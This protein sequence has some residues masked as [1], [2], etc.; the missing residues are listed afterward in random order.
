MDE[1]AVALVM[2]VVFA[3]G[4][5]STRLGRADLSA[6]II[7]VT[8][9]LLLSQAVHVLE[10]DL[11]HEAIKLLAEVTLVWVLF[12]D[13]SRVGIR[14]LRADLGLYT[15]L[16]AVGLPLTMAAGALLAMWLFDGMGVWMALVV[17]AA[18]APTDAA[19]GA[20]VMTDPAVPERIRRVLNVESGL[21]DGI[22]TPVVMFA[23][24]GAAAAGS[25]AAV[26]GGGGGLTQLAIGLA[27]GIGIGAVGGR[28]MRTARRRG[29]MSEDFAGP[30]VLALALAAYAATLWL[31]GNGFVAAFVAGLAF[32]N[33][34]GRGGVKEVFYVE[35]TAGFVSLLTW[36]TFGAVAVP[37]VLDELDWRVAGYAVLSLT[38]VRMLPVALV[39]IG[40]RLTPATVAFVGWF[41][42][43]GLASIIF[44]L[45]ALEDLHG[46]ADRVVA[47]IGTTVLFSVFA[48]GLTAK[49]LAS[50]YGATAAG[51]APAPAAADTPAQLPIRGLL[52]HHRA[53]AEPPRPSPE[54][55]DGR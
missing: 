29:W 39:L 17:G 48:H 34:A 3:W 46:E 6:P 52:H 55:G 1:A 20:A 21:N 37:I 9:G 41:G 8:V 2:L 19:L 12:A 38:V 5:F 54:P 26:S 15:R 24:A 4:L 42:P 13:A 18:L 10:P 44:A 33:S 30:G 14:E 47:I 53:A 25:I 31:D 16:L 27:V 36:L 23:I 50:R 22:A 45:I 7:F 11:S 32:G 28:A 35:Q 49:P 43:R 51:T 40:A